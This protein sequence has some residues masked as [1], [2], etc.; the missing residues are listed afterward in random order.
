[1]SVWAHDLPSTR[2]FVFTLV[3]FKYWS[4][5]SGPAIF[6]GC[7]MLWRAFELLSNILNITIL[8]Y[9]ETSVLVSW[10][11]HCTTFWALSTTNGTMQVAVTS[12]TVQLSIFQTYW[13][14]LPASTWLDRQILTGRPWQKHPLQMS[15]LSLS[16]Q[17]LEC[18]C[19]LEHNHHPVSQ[20]CGPILPDTS[21]FCCRN[22]E[23]LR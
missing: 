18:I 3:F 13:L 22:L 2:A 6:L 4:V 7:P 21:A 16:G 1:M 11:V 23:N 10:R 9:S 5:S 8:C 14:D 12:T 15:C 19:V 17:R 20:P